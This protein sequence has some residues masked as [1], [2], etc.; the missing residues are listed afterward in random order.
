MNPFLAL[1]TEDELLIA[2]LLLTAVM[3]LCILCYWCG[4]EWSQYQESLRRY[5]V[6]KRPPVT[7][8]TRLERYTTPPDPED[9][10]LN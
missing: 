1:G 5:A 4:Y 9:Y 3:V 10:K 6:S 7:R 2:L 8:K